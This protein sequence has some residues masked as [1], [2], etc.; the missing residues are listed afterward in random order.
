MTQNKQNSEYEEL[1]TFLFD[2]L[3]EVRLLEERFTE[4]NEHLQDAFLTIENIL[5]ENE[6]MRKDLFSI[7]TQMEKHFD[8]E[9]IYGGLSE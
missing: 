1:R 8:K 9:E 4:N 6:K 2:Y 7:Q 5:S 3:H